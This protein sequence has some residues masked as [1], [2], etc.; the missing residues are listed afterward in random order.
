MCRQA[1]ADA[2]PALE[3]DFQMSLTEMV[4]MVKTRDMEV[5]SPALLSRRA[6]ATIIRI[7]ESQREQGSTKYD[8]P[9]IPEVVP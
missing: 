9:C 5:T 7:A 8:K 1:L 6:R 3:S 2:R 4:H